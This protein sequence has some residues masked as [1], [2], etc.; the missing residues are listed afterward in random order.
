MRRAT[1]GK[2]RGGPL[3]FIRAILSTFSGSGRYPLKLAYCALQF[4]ENKALLLIARRFLMKRTLVMLGVGFAA[5]ASTYA[6]TKL[7]NAPAVP[8]RAMAWIEG[9][10]FTMG[11]DSD[12]GWP[13]ERPAHRVRVDG[14][15]IDEHEVTN[16]E[17]AAFVAATRYVTTAE[18]GARGPKTS[19]PSLRRGRPRRLR[20]TL[21]PGSLVFQPDGGRGRPPGLRPV[22]ALDSRGKLAASGR[23]G[24]RHRWEGK[25]PGRPG[26]LGRRRRLRSV[27]RQATPDR[28]RVGVRGSR[29]TRR[30]TLHL[31]RLAVLARP[32]ASQHLARGLPVPQHALPTAT[33]ALRR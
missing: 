21:V 9:G 3:W 15:W 30:P 12:L 18:T 11:T 8:P 13:D 29:W 6:A 5:F 23:A 33:T 2:D 10:E 27:G 24:Q 7:W 16:D 25:S 19:S 17:F 26:L 31:G 14:F 4:L 1:P 22:V 32:A 20:R 28:G